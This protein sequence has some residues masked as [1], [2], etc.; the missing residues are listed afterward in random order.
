MTSERME[1]VVTL[2]QSILPPTGAVT[3]NRELVEARR[4]GTPPPMISA[5]RLHYFL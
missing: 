3:K 1:A 5:R 2:A 4:V